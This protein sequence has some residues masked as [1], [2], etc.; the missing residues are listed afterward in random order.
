MNA[1]GRHLHISERILIAY[2][3]LKGYYRGAGGSG[4]LSPT[5]VGVL[6]ILGALGEATPSE[7]AR[8]LRAA[9]S[10]MTHAL[11][12]LERRRL[13]RRVRERQDRRSVSIVLTRRGRG[14][15]N[16]VHAA[17][18]GLDVRVKGALTAIEYQ[19]LLRALHTVEEAARE[20]W[21]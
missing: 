15:A 7:M 10:S 2:R 8:T 5:E 13:V 12:R 14:M 19:A 3:Q 11:D 18:Q 16:R 4:Q 6:E 17:L 21:T 1:Q 20:G 9:R